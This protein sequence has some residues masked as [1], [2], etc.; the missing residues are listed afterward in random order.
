MR[1]NCVDSKN[2]V[3]ETLKSGTN[4][5]RMSGKCFPLRSWQG[6][7]TKKDIMMEGLSLDI[8]ENF[9][10]RNLCSSS[11]SHS[12]CSSINVSNKYI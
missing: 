3:V 1:M 4:F 8:K 12:K 5:G 6:K 9:G 7:T 10:V 11:A 2:R